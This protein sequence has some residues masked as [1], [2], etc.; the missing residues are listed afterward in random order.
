MFAKNLL[1]LAVFILVAGSIYYNEVYRAEE[2]KEAD[3]R[4]K[5]IFDVNKEDIHAFTLSPKDEHGSGRSH[6]ELKMDQEGDWSIINPVKDRANNV[7]VERILAE[8][9]ELQQTK[10]VTDDPANLAEYGLKEPASRLTFKKKGSE[11]NF[12][13]HMGMR[14]PVG[15]TTYV[16]RYP[17][18]SVYLVNASIESYLS[19]RLVDLRLR[20]PFDIPN[21]QDI[22]SLSLKFKSGEKILL[23][24][25]DGKWKVKEPFDCKLDQGAVDRLADAF[26]D[27]RV[28]HF[29]TEE[30]EDLV[31][32]GLHEPAL[33]IEASFVN[34][35]KKPVKLTVGKEATGK[36]PE[37]PTKDL[38]GWFAQTNLRKTIYVIA[39]Y[40]QEK[41]AKGLNTLRDRTVNPVIDVRNVPQLTLSFS[42]QKPISVVRDSY[43]WKVEG[44][45]GFDCDKLTVERIIDAVSSLKVEAFEA[46][47]VKSLYKWGLHK[48]NLS[49]AIT[50]KTTGSEKTI[51]T[52][53]AWKDKKKVFVTIGDEKSVYRLKG[54]ILLK[55]PD[56]PVD[57]L[58]RRLFGLIDKNYI[59]KVEISSAGLEDITLERTKKAGETDTWKLLRPKSQAVQK[60]KADEWVMRFRSMKATEYMQQGRDLNLRQYGLNKPLAKV[61]II[62]RDEKA[63]QFWLQ[64]GAITEDKLF[65]YANCSTRDAIFKIRR[66]DA[67]LFLSPSFLDV[68]KATQ[69]ND[70]SGLYTATKDELKTLPQAVFL[71][72]KGVFRTILFEKEAPN[73]VANFISLAE[74]GFYEGTTFHRVEKF[75]IQGGDPNSKDSDPKNDGKGGPGYTI[76]DEL[77]PKRKHN[78]GVLSM[79]H[80][81]PNTGGSQF[82]VTKTPSSWLDNVH[83][84][85]G[86][87]LEG[88]DVV[89]KITKGTKVEKI[90]IE[91]T[92]SRKFTPKTNKK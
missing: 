34:E 76:A 65:H 85:F 47:N 66:K 48:P 15:Y 32:Y 10:L 3:R 22:A 52:N 81:G 80:R 5:L 44:N 23:L 12:E 64:V 11:E 70:V 41:L 78:R 4:A 17:N 16:R 39:K 2:I 33:V 28:D 90:T 42:G 89:D 19:K 67:K 38:A 30:P 79:A 73:T 69:K 92:G 68:G 50:E 24:Q 46:D 43:Q 82:F 62:P 83:T 27:L 86:A 40:Q 75:C 18:K 91:N 7:E 49:V 1:L 63:E 56:K 59:K 36:Q 53:F 71:T 14:N 13:L 21:R 87:V 20:K 57:L 77:S 60:N 31:N 8:L 84:V 25:S 29:I 45:D 51:K 6:V 61:T 55:L 35:N 72:E 37:D 74:K 26:R 88:M 9:T 58:T 54:D